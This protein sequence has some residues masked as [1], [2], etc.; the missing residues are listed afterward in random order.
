MMCDVELILG[1][2]YILPLL[3]CVYM[4]I[5]IAQ[6]KDVFVCDFVENIKLTQHEFYR[7]YCD[8]YT[9][10]ND[11]T[12]NDFNAIETITNDV[13]PMNWFFYLNGGN[14]DVY[15]AFLFVGHKYLVYQ[16]DLSIVKKIQLV[17]KEFF[18][19]DMD[20]MKQ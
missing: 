2:L 9:R 7:L 12:F 16:H 15:L 3:E 5:K 19:L 20:K 14:N 11:P 4:L 17:T 1:L 18:K 6:G 13:I 10:F 8:P